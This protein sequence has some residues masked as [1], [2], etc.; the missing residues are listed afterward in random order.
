MARG[1]ESKGVEEQIGAA[2]AER[3]LR[4]KPVLSAEEVELNVRRE[5]L[6][7]SRARLAAALEAAG[8]PRYRAQ[9]ERALEHLDAEIAALGS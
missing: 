6:L 8:D 3:E 9:L 1:W 4:G 2:E 7:L 5:G